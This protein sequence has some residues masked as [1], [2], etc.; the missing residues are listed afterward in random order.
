MPFDPAKYP[1]AITVGQLIERGMKI[2]LHCFDC[3]HFAVADPAALPLKHEEFVPALGGRFRC[4]RCGS[5][6]TE[7]RPHFPYLFA[8]DPGA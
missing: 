6:K 3:A 1:D 2:G 5:V 7:A 4:T 8:P